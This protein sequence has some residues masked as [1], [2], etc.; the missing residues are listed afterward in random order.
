MGRKI[1]VN[2]WSPI[3]LLRAPNRVFFLLLGVIVL[4]LGII[5]L[6]TIVV[7]RLVRKR[8]RVAVAG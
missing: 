5:V 6:V 7:V 2:S 3:G 8:K 1:E 4:L